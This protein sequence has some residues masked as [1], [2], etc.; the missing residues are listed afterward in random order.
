MLESSNLL[1]IPS[2]PFL[3][4]IPNSFPLS[5]HKDTL[6]AHPRSWH[7]GAWNLIGGIGFTLCGAL[8][9][10]SANSGCVYQGSLATFWGSW[11]FLIG[12]VI[13]WF[14]SLDKHPVSVSVDGSASLVDKPLPN[15]S[16]WVVFAG[17]VWISCISGKQ[18]TLMVGKTAPAFWIS[19]GVCCGSKRLHVRLDTHEGILGYQKCLHHRPV[20]SSR[21]ISVISTSSYSLTFVDFKIKDLVTNFEWN[22]LLSERDSTVS[23]SETNFLS[24]WLCCF[25]SDVDEYWKIHIRP[26]PLLTTIYRQSISQRD[27]FSTFEF[28]LL[29]SNL[30][31]NLKITTQYLT[32]AKRGWKESWFTIRDWAL[33]EVHLRKSRV[34]HSEMKF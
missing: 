34:S 23:L 21:T 5:Y 19:I 16:S 1:T 28:W 12:S 10:A 25:S 15:S 13:Q 31:G 20:I 26:K 9:F 4:A 11:C 17:C 3:P 30:D 33:I 7:I 22:R 24:L 27:R 32:R 14:E 18:V 6:T 2:N 29:S 8:G